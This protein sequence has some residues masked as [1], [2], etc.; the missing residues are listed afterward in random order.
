[1][2]KF[3]DN[4]D[5]IVDDECHLC[6]VIMINSTQLM[7]YDELLSLTVVFELLKKLSSFAKNYRLCCD[8]H[9]NGSLYSVRTNYIIILR[10]MNDLLILVKNCS[11]DEV[12]DVEK[13]EEC[14]N[15]ASDFFLNRSNIVL[16]ELEL[17]LIDFSFKQVFPTIYNSIK[18]NIW[19]YIKS[20]KELIFIINSDNLLSPAVNILSHPFVYSNVDLLRRGLDALDTMNIFQSPKYIVMLFDAM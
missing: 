18:D 17:S 15:M 1:M 7:H 11:N 13:I 2:L 10:I 20:N 14:K 8:N 9:S 16:N 5:T 4:L 19:P 3:L 12:I 6:F